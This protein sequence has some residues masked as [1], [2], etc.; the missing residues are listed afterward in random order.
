MTR[1]MTEKSVLG[2]GKFKDYSVG[3]L[4]S[5]E[6]HQY[7]RWVYYNCSNIN[8]FE[9]ILDKIGIKKNNY[10]AKPGIYKEGWK[11]RVFEFAP[12]TEERLRQRQSRGTKKYYKK[13]RDYNK[14]MGANQ[15]IYSAIRLKNNNQKYI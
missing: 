12:M 9:D 8:F 10:I 13:K 3:Q 14:A 1:K 7:L 4:L 6:E 2:F 11:E 5:L 15:N